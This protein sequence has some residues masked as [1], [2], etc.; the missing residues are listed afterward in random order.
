MYTC[1]NWTPHEPGDKQ[2]PAA[3]RSLQPG[4]QESSC[5]D[6]RAVGVGGVGYPDQ[7]L[8]NGLGLDWLSGGF[9]L[10]VR[11]LWCYASLQVVCF[12]FFFCEV[13]YFIICLQFCC[14][15]DDMGC[16]SMDLGSGLVLP[17]RNGRAVSL[18]GFLEGE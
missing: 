5:A 11:G 15:A 10:Y 9:A 12:F 8:H 3:G 2:N 6:G 7:E 13:S 14:G 17:C 18:T 1:Q 4:S 16:F